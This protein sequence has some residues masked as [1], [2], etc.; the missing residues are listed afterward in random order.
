M[1]RNYA[2]LKPV[3]TAIFVPGNRLDRVDKAINTDAD[4]VIIDLE[5][6]VPL[7]QKEEIRPGVHRKLVEHKKRK[8]IVRVNAL[9]SEFIK[10]DLESIILENLF[11]I[12]VP[13]VEDPFHI[14]EINGLILDLETSKGIKQGSI[15]II[16]LIE[17]AKGIQNIFRI[18]SQKINPV[19]LFT[20]AFGAADYSLDLGIELTKDITQFDYAR[21]RI[22]IACR[23]SGIEPP[24]DTPSM[25]D[26]KDKDG[27]AAQAKRAK[28]LGFQGKLCIHP[29]QIE[30]CNEIFFPS[31]EEIL[32]ARRVVEAFDE[33][34]AKGI[35]AIQLEGKFIDMPVVEQARRIL[36]L[37]V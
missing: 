1:K 30:I 15:W 11:G 5:D 8:I 35:A 23:A 21:S 33:A 13:K 16:P 3:R 26:L 6:S 4:A 27:L 18:L 34:E 22:A 32:H 20:A 29:N 24:L 36:S 10:G 37:L 17:S 31:K 7:D 14:Q 28:E 25:L 2:G 19:R 12:M 9:D